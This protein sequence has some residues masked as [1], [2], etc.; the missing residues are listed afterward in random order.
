M[1]VSNLLHENGVKFISLKD[2]YQKL[3]YEYYKVIDTLMLDTLMVEDLKQFSL[4]FII[5]ILSRKDVH[6]MKLVAVSLEALMNLKHVAFF[7]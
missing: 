5:C 1:Q 6:D 7:N 3:S 2:F 4:S